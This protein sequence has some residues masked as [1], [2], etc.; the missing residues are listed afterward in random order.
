[1]GGIEF[2]YNSIIVLLHKLFNTKVCIGV[3][4]EACMHAATDMCSL[5]KEV[6][7]AST[8]AACRCLYPLNF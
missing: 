7:M 5:Q 3:L 8:T 6:I 2:K 4:N 1:M